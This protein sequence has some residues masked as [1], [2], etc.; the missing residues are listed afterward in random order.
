VRKPT[1]LLVS[2]MDDDGFLLVATEPGR[3]HLVVIAPIERNANNTY[4]LDAARKIRD[5]LNSILGDV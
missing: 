1:P 5:Q 4:G 2:N 3:P